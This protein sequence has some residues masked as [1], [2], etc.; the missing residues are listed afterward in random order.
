LIGLAKPI[1]TRAGAVSLL[2]EH[3]AG[4]VVT[5]GVVADSTT[6]AP[7]G[8]YAPDTA[9][10]GSNDYMVMYEYDATLNRDA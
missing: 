2:K 8:T 1:K 5:N 3:A 6:G 7:N 10:D 9:A 4:S